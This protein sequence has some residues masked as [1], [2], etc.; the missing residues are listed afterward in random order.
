MSELTD[1]LTFPNEYFDSQKT[2]GFVQGKVIEN[3]NKDH[4]GMVKVEFT[5]WEEKKNICEG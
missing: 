4:P 1:L 2:P 3:N 5:A